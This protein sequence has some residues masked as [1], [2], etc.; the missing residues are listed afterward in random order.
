M[1]A[2]S[3]MLSA[4][5]AKRPVLYIGGGCL[6]ASAEVRTL[7]SFLLAVPVVSSM[8]CALCLQLRTG[9]D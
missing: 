5:Q 8:H 2:A 4:A 1:G 6:D 3:D 7:A 9:S